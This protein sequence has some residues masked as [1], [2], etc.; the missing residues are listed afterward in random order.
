MQL[1]APPD[2]TQRPQRHARLLLVITALNQ[3]EADKGAAHLLGGV[4]VGALPIPLRDGD[5]GAQSVNL[6]PRPLQLILQ[7]HDSSLL[8][9]E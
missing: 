3:T 5:F 9:H 1:R 8:L 7:L 6:R 4:F 2:G